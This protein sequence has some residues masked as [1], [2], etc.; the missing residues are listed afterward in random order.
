MTKT[1]IQETAI[2]DLGPATVDNYKESIRRL[3]KIKECAPE[4]N[5]KTIN[6]M[7]STCNYAMEW[8]RDGFPP[9]HRRGIERRRSRDV[10][11]VL[12]DP[13]WFERN[14][15]KQVL[16]EPANELTEPQKREIRWILGM[17][18]IRERQCFV[19]KS[20]TDWSIEQIGKELG[21]SKGSV[22]SMLSRANKKL[23]EIRAADRDQIR[24]Y[25]N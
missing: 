4:E 12:W 25:S 23:E 20:T 8:V 15:V 5:R 16:P 13:V 6:G 3:K 10:S 21:I 14:N 18:S 9:D 2:V 17:L 19:L 11:T 1:P 24:K 22:Q 7:I